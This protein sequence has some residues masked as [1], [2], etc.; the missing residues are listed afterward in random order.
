V[1][2]SANNISGHG[3]GRQRALAEN[4]V[5]ALKHLSFRNSM[6]HQFPL[7]DKQVK[8][9]LDVMKRTAAFLKKKLSF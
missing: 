3:G 2:N 9:G 6:M 7:V 8:A 1:G 5:D 4:E